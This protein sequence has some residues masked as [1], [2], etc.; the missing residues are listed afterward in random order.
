M[1][2]GE[3]ELVA[4]ADHRNGITGEPFDVVLFDYIPPGEPPER[5]MGIVL[6]DESDQ[7]LGQVCCFVLSPLLAAQGIITF[8]QNSYRGDRFAELL[9]T[10]IAKAKKKQRKSKEKSEL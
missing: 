7:E 1:L 6:S 10:L 4:H 2:E 8:R 5:L 9:R 3:I